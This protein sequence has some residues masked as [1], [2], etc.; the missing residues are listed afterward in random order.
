MRQRS[1]IF[2]SLGGSGRL[3]MAWGDW[4]VI[5]WTL[6]EELQIEAQARS[7]F[8]HHDADEVRSLC[9]S[10]IKQNAYYAKLIRQATGRISELELSA[11]ICEDKPHPAHSSLTPLANPAARYAKLL[12]NGALRLLRRT[13]AMVSTHNMP[14]TFF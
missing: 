5:S 4:M 8:I 3:I 9:A 2:S 7:A 11:L 13:K 1:P 10:L 6:E 14:I 12:C